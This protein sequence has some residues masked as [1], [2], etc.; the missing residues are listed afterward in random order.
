MQPWSFESLTKIERKGKTYEEIQT[1]R[2]QKWEEKH[3][4][5]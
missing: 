3:K 5:N 1:L 4:V 2:K